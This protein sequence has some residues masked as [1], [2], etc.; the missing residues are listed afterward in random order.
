MSLV[1]YKTIA[2][3]YTSDAAYISPD[4]VD[5][6]LVLLASVRL[7]WK[8]LV[9]TNSL[10]YLNSASITTKKGFSWSDK[11]YF[12][13]GILKGDYTVPLTSCLTRLESVV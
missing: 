13:Q 1:E 12:D 2:G 10:T 3:V 6:L 8:G 5:R 9:G 4:H 11:W 7:G